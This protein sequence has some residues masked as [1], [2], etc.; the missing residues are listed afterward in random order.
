M[1]DFQLK[2]V[3]EERG[4]SIYELTSKGVVKQRTVYRI[5]EKPGRLPKEETVKALCNYFSVPPSELIKVSTEL[6][7]T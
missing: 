7:R 3:M 2:T 4:V 1:I 6:I 5:L